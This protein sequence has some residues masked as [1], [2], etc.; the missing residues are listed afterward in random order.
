MPIRPAR[1]RNRQVDELDRRLEQDAGQKGKRRRDGA[2]HSDPTCDERALGEDQPEDQPSG[3]GLAQLAGDGAEADVGKLSDDD[4][5][6]D[7]KSRQENEVF[8]ANVVAL[9]GLR[10]LRAQRRPAL[11]VGEILDIIIARTEP[12]PTVKRQTVE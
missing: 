5:G 2:P 1:A 8:H 4:L 6:G 7:D 3:L 9:T 12:T 11:T 10:V